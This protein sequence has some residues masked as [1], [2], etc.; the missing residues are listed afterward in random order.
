[1][2]KCKRNEDEE[3]NKDGTASR[4]QQ[5]RR[6]RFNH[7]IKENDKQYKYSVSIRLKVLKRYLEGEG[8]MSPE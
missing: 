3:L 4:K 8:L 7:A 2:V 5:Y 1:M 6:K